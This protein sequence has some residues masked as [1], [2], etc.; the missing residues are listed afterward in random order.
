MAE[1]LSKTTIGAL[2]A[3]FSVSFFFFLPYTELTNVTD[4]SWWL[5]KDSPSRRTTGEGRARPRG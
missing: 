4:A 3:F 2:E 1:R 5:A